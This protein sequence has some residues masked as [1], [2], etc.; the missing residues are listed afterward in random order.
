[1]SIFLSIN[2]YKNKK[3]NNT[4]LEVTTA[5]PQRNM[6]GKNEINVID[7]ASAKLFFRYLIIIIVKKII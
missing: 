4:M 6:I 3:S 1:M 7:N 5:D 2:I